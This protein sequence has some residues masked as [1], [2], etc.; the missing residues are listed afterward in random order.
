MIKYFTAVGKVSVTEY[1]KN[2]NVIDRTLCKFSH[3]V[4]ADTSEEA[5]EKVIGY[6]VDKGTNLYNFSLASIEIFDFI[7]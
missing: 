5:E 3:V 1:D 4:Q 6:Y 2:Y 7:S